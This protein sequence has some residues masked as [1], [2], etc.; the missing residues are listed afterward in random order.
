MPFLKQGEYA[1]SLVVAPIEPDYNY[2]PLFFDEVV[3]AAFRLEN[4]I[5]SATA[6]GTFDVTESAAYDP[7]FDPISLV[8]EQHKMS[9]RAYVGANNQAEVDRVTQRL[10]GELANQE[11]VEVDG[12]LGALA[13]FVADVFDPIRFVIVLVVVLFSKQKWIAGRGGGG[14]VLVVA[15]FSKK[16][17]IV[18][19]AATLSAIT[20]ETILYSTQVARIWGEGIPLGFLAGLFH[21]TIVFIILWW[22][23][24]LKEQ[25]AGAKTVDVCRK[26]GLLEATFYKWKAKFG[27]L[28]VSDAKRLRALEEENTKLKKLLA[29]AMLDNAML[30]DIN[31]KK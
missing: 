27:G 15:L 22:R 9:A 25:E 3:P 30:K 31:S 5:A 16:K 11:T 7:N 6:E 14:E 8:P 10:D 21:A 12:G 4:S 19:W 20:V 26:H 1:Q 17:W 18:I 29:E 23:D 2:E 28:E 13:V 24:I